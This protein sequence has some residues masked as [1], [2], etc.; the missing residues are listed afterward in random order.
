MIEK[1]R[2][3]IDA[4]RAK[5]D[6]IAERFGVSAN[7][8]YAAAA[9]LILLGVA[10]VSGL[11]SGHPTPAQLEAA[12]P[13][14]VPSPQPAPTVQQAQ[15]PAPMQT[16]P[17]TASAATTAPAAPLQVELPALTTPASPMKSGA[18]QLTV[19]TIAAAPVQD[20]T[21]LPGQT[22]GT[23]VKSSPTAS[24]SGA[25]PDAMA[26]FVTAGKPVRLTY[27]FN[28]NAPT[29]GSYLLTTNLS[30]N[31]SAAVR[32][33]LDG[34]A[35]ALVTLKRNF[36]AL[37]AADAPAQAGSASVTLAAGMHSVEAVL[38]TTAATQA[39][40]APTLDFYIKP[41]T[42]PMPAAMVPLW[43][44]S[45]PAAPASAPAARR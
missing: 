5:L 26:A 10:V 30:G 41:A 39:A 12:R 11:L 13:V 38:D 18:W 6:P 9:F 31:A 2:D 42:A 35:D 22:V 7:L 43:P 40:H 15:E 25:V 32:V 36:N 29:T 33:M 27:S 3:Q 8:L 23:V 44:A 34:R 24:F 17:A 37:W 4:I 16:Q 1:L 20:P 14:A 21:T 19:Q 28:F 45:A